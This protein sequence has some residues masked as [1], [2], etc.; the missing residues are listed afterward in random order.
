MTS[1]NAAAVAAADGDDNDD[2][3]SNFDKL[4]MCRIASSYCLSVSRVY[5]TSGSV[6]C[7]AV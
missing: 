7:T 1:V 4:C 2:N 5:K 6:H 3:S